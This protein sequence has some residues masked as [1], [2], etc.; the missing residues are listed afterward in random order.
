MTFRNYDPERDRPAV[1]RIWKEVGWGEHS[2][3]EDRERFIECGRGMVAELN[4]EAE[5]HVCTCPGTIRYLEEDLPFSCVTGVTTSRIARKQ[6]FA[7]R[8]LAQLLAV[9]AAEGALVAGLGMFEQGFYNQ[10]GFGTGGYEHWVS[11]DPA[12]LNVSVTPRVPRR[13]AVD[14]WEAAHAARLARIRGHGNCSLTPAG[15]TR[16]EMHEG[17]KTFGLGYFDGP[18]GTLTHCVWCGVRGGEHGPYQVHWMAYQTRDQFLELMALIRSLGDQVRLIQMCEPPGLQLQDLIDRPF[19]QI[20]ATENSKYESKIEAHAYW[21]MRILDLPG[22]LARTRLRGGELRLN[23]RLTDPIESLLDEDAPWRGVGEEYIVMFGD[24]S[25]AE[26]GTDPTLATLATTVNAFTRLWLG[27]RSATSLAVTD[28]L[29]GPED[30]L[31]ELD[32]VLRLPQP[33]PDWGF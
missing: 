7:K 11:F 8:L 33:H 25:S 2:S 3:D 32:W 4:G 9:D 28:E 19:Q 16:A 23:L 22:C 1:H 31:Q 18:A 5:C 12:R 26:R 21:Q 29:S 15:I 30:L 14:D 6:G 13:I 10:L 17:E 24:P 27:V 20:I